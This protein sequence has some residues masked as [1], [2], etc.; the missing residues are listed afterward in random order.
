MLSLM[1]FGSPPSFPNPG[2]VTTPTPPVSPAATA[3]TFDASG[4]N[5]AAPGINQGPGDTSYFAFKATFTGRVV[6]NL[7][8][9]TTG[10]GTGLVPL[11]IVSDGRHASN[12][13]GRRHG[14]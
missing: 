1:P 5:A 6:F 14:N 11:L 10:F 13:A 2:P 3:L 9:P 8:A 12:A 4:R 7:A